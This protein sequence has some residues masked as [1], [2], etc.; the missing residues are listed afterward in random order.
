Q[1]HAQRQHTTS[2]PH[3]HQKTSEDKH[4]SHSTLLPHHESVRG[5]CPEATK[6]LTLETFDLLLRRLRCMQQ[7]TVLNQHRRLP[8]MRCLFVVVC[9]ADEIAIMPLPCADL[10]SEW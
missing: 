3:M 1:P 9:P 5:A 7:Q 2:Y 10:D 6:G 4:A 8:M